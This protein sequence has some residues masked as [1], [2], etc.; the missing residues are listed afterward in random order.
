MRL[1]DLRLSQEMTLT[2]VVRAMDMTNGRDTND[3]EWALLPAGKVLVT[4]LIDVEPSS[5][6]SENA[7]Q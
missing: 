5:Q 2:G 7:E 6:D 3:P 1:R 4:L